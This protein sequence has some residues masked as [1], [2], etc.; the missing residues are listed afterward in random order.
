V[1]FSSQRRS[2]RERTEFGNTAGATRRTEAAHNSSQPTHGRCHIQKP[3]DFSQTF[4]SVELLEIH[5]RNTAAHRW[6]WGQ[7]NPNLSHIGVHRSCVWICVLL[8]Q[9]ND[10]PLP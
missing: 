3:P 4:S 1:P 10:R 7:S 9:D 8:P 6:R 5:S 2:G